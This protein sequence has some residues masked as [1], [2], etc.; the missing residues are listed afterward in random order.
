MSNAE[1]KSA[2]KQVIL[3]S[4]ARFAL[5]VNSH[6]KRWEIKN[7]ITASVICVGETKSLRVSLPRGRERK[8]V[9]ATEVAQKTNDSLTQGG[10]Q[11]EKKKKLP[12]PVLRWQDLQRTK[13]ENKQLC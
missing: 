3:R 4:S 6:D 1:N 9:K 7:K 12:Y 8:T 2:G 10:L 11:E 13:M 5:L